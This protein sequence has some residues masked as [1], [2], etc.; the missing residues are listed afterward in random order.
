M[1]ASI[2]TPEPRRLRYVII[3]CAGII[4]AKHIEVLQQISSAQIVGMADVAPHGAER[5]AQVGCPFFSDYRACL[6]Q[7]QPVA[8]AGLRRR[9]QNQHVCA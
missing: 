4:A 2:S 9:L 7:A 6:A 5:A 8:S 3:G 1:E